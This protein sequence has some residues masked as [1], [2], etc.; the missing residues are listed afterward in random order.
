ME[1]DQP[2]INLSEAETHIPP[3]IFIKSNMLNFSGFCN[4]IKPQLVLTI[5]TGDAI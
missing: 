3:P 5:L 2:N 1:T 4:A